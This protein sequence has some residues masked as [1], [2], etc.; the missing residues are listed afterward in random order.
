MSSR[1]SCH[2]YNMRTSFHSASLSCKLLAASTVCVHPQCQCTSIWHTMSSDQNSTSP[3]LWVPFR[4][5]ICSWM[6]CVSLRLNKMKKH[7]PHNYKYPLLNCPHILQTQLLALLILGLGTSCWDILLLP[8][9]IFTISVWYGPKRK[10]KVIHTSC[11]EITFMH[12][13]LHTL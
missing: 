5:Y 11:F 6:S 8:M 7:S 9:Y 12:L 2:I 1:Q 10:N 3:Y 4:S 13:L